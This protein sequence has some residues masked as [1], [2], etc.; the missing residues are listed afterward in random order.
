MEITGFAINADAGLI[1]GNMNTLRKELS[2]YQELGFPFAEVSPHGVGA[3]YNGKLH[4]KRLREVERLFR[5]YSLRYTVHGPNPMNLMNE[6]PGNIEWDLFAASLEFTAA[7]GADI[8]VYHAGRYLPEEHFLLPRRPDST[9]QERQRLWD[10]EKTELQRLAELADHYKVTIAVE[11]ARPYLDS[12]HYTYGESLVELGRMIREVGHERIGITLDMGHAHLAACRYGYDLLKEVAIIAPYIKHIHMHDN[13]GR[14]CASTERKQYE[15]T[16][17]GRGDMHMPIGWGT[18][19]AG[20][21]LAVISDYTGVITLELRPRYRD[22]YG[23]ALENARQIVA[24]GK[25]G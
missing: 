14:C 22:N 1:D 3:I 15:M 12:N 23:E 21:I 25:V 16:A 7:I 5:E 19:P 9:T 2:Y 17:T 8:M 24:A 11:N 4:G 18:V 20:E 6:D 10:K 13:C